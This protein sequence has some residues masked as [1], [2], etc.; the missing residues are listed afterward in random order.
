M[1]KF[2]FFDRKGFATLPVRADNRTVSSL[3]SRSYENIQSLEVRLEGGA[4]SYVPR[5]VIN[6]VILIIISDSWG[7]L[8]LVAASLRISPYT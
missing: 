4:F 2:A 6:Y 5:M 8:F 1:E 3:L 7:S